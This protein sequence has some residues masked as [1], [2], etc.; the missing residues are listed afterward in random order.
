MSAITLHVGGLDFRA[1]TRAD[2][3]RALDLDFARY[4]GLADPHS[5]RRVIAVAIKDGLL[6]EG[7]DFRFSDPESETP[8]RGRPSK[9]AY[10]LTRRGGIKAVTRLNT[11]TAIAMIN[12]VVDV[13]LKADAMLHEPPPVVALA[14]DEAVTRFCAGAV[15]I[16]EHPRLFRQM[17]DKIAYAAFKAKV[18]RQRIAGLVRRVFR[19]T[20]EYAILVERADFVLDLLDAVIDDASV[21]VSRGTPKLLAPRMANP[22]QRALFDN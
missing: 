17:R 14:H 20:S 3:P 11:P 18:S 7:V 8:K 19:S 22:K 1:D 5:I 4:L 13:F 6:C 2:E 9:L 15:R 16:E 12:E 21:L 10:E